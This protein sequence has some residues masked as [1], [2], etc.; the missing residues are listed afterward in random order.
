MTY[1]KHSQLGD[2]KKSI[3]DINRESNKILKELYKEKGI[4]KCE[5]C[6]SSFWLS[7]A[8]KHKRVWYRANPELLSSFYHTLLLCIPCH[9]DLEFDKEL[10]KETFENL[11]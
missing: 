9:Q 10:T 5:L 4:T 8:H 7:F 6:G 1:S 2:P 11:R 3:T